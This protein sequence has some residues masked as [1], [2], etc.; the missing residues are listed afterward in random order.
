TVATKS[1]KLKDDTGNVEVIDEAIKENVK[2]EEEE[3][4]EVKEAEAKVQIKLQDVNDE[5]AKVKIL[6]EEEKENLIEDEEEDKVNLLEE[7]KEEDREIPQDGE[8]N[9]DG[10]DKV[11]LLEEVKEQIEVKEADEDL[12]NTVDSKE[13]ELDSKE[14]QEINLIQHE[15][16]QADLKEDKI[17]EMNCL[18]PKKVTF[19]PPLSPEVF[20]KNQPPASPLRRGNS[21]F[22]PRRNLFSPGILKRSNLKNELKSRKLFAVEVEGGDEV[23]E[24]E[25]VVEGE[26]GE[27]MNDIQK[28]ECGNPFQLINELNDVDDSSSV[29]SLEVEE[30][31]SRE[32]E[33][34]HNLEGNKNES[35]KATEFQVKEFQ[36]DAVVEAEV[37]VYKE[38]K[39]NQTEIQ[40]TLVNE[41]EIEESKFIT[42]K[43]ES[44]E[45]P[46][47]VPTGSVEAPPEISPI[48]T[49]SRSK[50]RLTLV[51]EKKSHKEEIVKRG[52]GRPKK[53]P[54]DSKENENV[55]ESKASESKVG[56]VKDSNASI[57]DSN[58]SIKDL[59]SSINDSNAFIKDL[60]LKR[61]LSEN[62]QSSPRRGR[63]K[64]IKQNEPKD[65]STTI[66]TLDTTTNSKHNIQTLIFLQAQEDP[67]V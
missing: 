36:G 41:T 50:K 62:V 53:T 14:D 25:G 57:E 56:N 66:S 26:R 42:S 32:I 24:G 61:T 34:S 45:I 28:V 64:K 10:E 15:D 31:F 5:E 12:Q 54:N 6:V 60:T 2:E 1:D 59:T 48:K 44:N 22:S 7:V 33:E 40:V 58:T 52:R 43:I 16:L 39:E 49:R 29:H 13:H 17:N 4:A 3:N 35:V 23:V 67:L 9:Q 20:D 55:K 38:S 27:E 21:P 18:T 8:D 51:E 65:L 37:K 11:N 47:E 63:P 30:I 19:G 46:P